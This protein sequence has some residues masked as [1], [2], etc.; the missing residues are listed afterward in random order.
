MNISTILDMAAEA[1]GDRIGVVSG[2]QRWSY[3]DLRGAAQAAAHHIK[4]SGAQ[5]VAMLDVTSPAAPVAIFAAAYAGVPYVPLNY[6]L[7]RPEI[8]ELIERIAPAYL[9][10]GSEY[11]NLVAPRNDVQ[12]IERSDFLRLKAPEG[13]E[14]LQPEEDPRA[15]AVQL[16]TS[17]TTGKPKAAILRHEN[18]MSYIVGT[19]EFASADESDA[20][21]VTV[22][23]YHIAGISAVL[24]ST[25]ACRRMVQLE[26]FDPKSWLAACR[27]NGVS[28]AF[29]VPTMLQRVVDYL[30]DAAAPPP[31]REGGAELRV[32]E[33]A[34]APAPAPASLREGAV[35]P[36]HL[37]SLRAIAYGG[38]KMP[39]STIQKAMQL[40]PNVDFTNAYGLTE[41]SSTIAVLG[42]ED[43]RAAAASSD[44]Q[45]SRR[46]GSVGKPG[47]V[48]LQIRDEDG[49]VLGAEEA[50]L[51][52]VRGAQVSGEYLSLGSQLD[53]EGWFPTKDRGYLDAEGYLFLDGRADDVIVRGG[54]NISPGEIEDVLLSHPAVADVAVVAMPDEQWGE[55]VAAAVVLKPGADVSV[56]ELQEL[57][58]NALRSSRVPQK[59]IFK[60]A[61]PYNETGKVLR[62]VIRQE[63]A[64]K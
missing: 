51:V 29:L 42:P 59:I 26:G 14:P 31:G 7:T 47:A 37:P 23:P 58:K 22:P 9:I 43:H 32:A 8:N 24:S 61:L 15:V 19:V 10:V 4:A 44:P 64:S 17:G 25:Y 39:L 50:G 36:V 1:F 11:R 52:F 55:G 38:G 35:S 3:A 34:A 48:E 57:V 6:R 49:K 5:Y 13:A 33:A 60:E 46:L 2:E 41:T 62:R 20:I 40:F 18:L 28:N 30:T 21:V 63:F 16:F 54:E 12:L 53:A 27:D 56:A 45:V